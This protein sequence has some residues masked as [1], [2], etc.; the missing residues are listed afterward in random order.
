MGHPYVAVFVTVFVPQSVAQPA[1]FPGAVT[2]TVGV[3]GHCASL[4]GIERVSVAI[5]AGAL[6]VEVTNL[7]TISIGQFTGNEELV[8]DTGSVIWGGFK[9]GMRRTDAGIWYCFGAREA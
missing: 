2:V 1:H 7:Q 8:V 9:D 3:V 6:Q 5:F 4:H